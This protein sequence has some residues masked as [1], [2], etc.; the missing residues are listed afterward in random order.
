MFINSFGFGYIG[1]FFSVDSILEAI[2]VVGW[3]FYSISGLVV[4]DGF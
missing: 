3:E 2:S 4:F 1:V